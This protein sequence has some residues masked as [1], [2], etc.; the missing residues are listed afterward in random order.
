MRL[1]DAATGEQLAA[2]EHD[3]AVWHLDFSPDG[4]RI[5]SSACEHTIML[6]EASSFGRQI[7]V[8]EGHSS[9]VSCIAFSP[10]C[11]TLASRSFDTTV[12]LWDAATGQQIAVLNGHDKTVDC[13]AFSPDGTVLAS[14]G[15]GESV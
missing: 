15:H 11:Q 9:R 3:S 8:L 4:G 10:I 1:W 13:L 6:C 12:R 14:S 2:F 7:A 5:A